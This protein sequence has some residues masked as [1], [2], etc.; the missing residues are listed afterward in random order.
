MSR[1]TGSAWCRR[2]NADARDELRRDRDRE[3][4][5]RTSVRRNAFERAGKRRKHDRVVRTPRATAL[6][7]AL[8]TA[9]ARRAMR[10]ASRERVPRP[11]R[12]SR[13]NLR[14]AKN[15]ID[16][17]SGDQNGEMPP[18]VPGSCQA[19]SIASDRSQSAVASSARALKT[20]SRPSGDMARMVFGTPSS[21]AG[22]HLT[23]SGRL[24]E[25]RHRSLGARPAVAAAG[26]DAWRREKLLRSAAI[27]RRTSVAETADCRFEFGGAV[28]ARARDRTPAA[29]RQLR[30]R[31][32]A[33]MPEQRSVAFARCAGARCAGCV[34][35]RLSAQAR[36]SGE[37]IF[38][39]E[40][41]IGNVGEPARRDPSRGTAAAVSGAAGGVSSG[42][43]FHSG[44]PRMTAP[45]VSATAT[46]GNARLAVSISYN[47]QPN[48]QMSLLPSTRSP[49]AC[50]GLT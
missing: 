24:M 37:Q 33:T 25:R 27:Q 34:Q 5:D 48:A 20:T 28:A 43:A 47:R 30:E 29:S 13:F 32:P 14:S 15:P 7:S 35:Q 18:S 38:D 45:S 49:M 26:F 40:A 31:T 11:F 46:P 6:A 21:T 17:L 41:S 19:S 44:S 1:D 12:S 8:R 22:G 16:A 2:E 4:R 10:S 23:P 36:T 39:F 3:G 50:S 42:K 9:F